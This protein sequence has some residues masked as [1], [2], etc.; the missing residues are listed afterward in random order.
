MSS[1][2]TTAELL[3]IDKPPARATGLAG[4]L[5]TK[6]Q[7]ATPKN[8]APDFAALPQ[9]PTE[10]LQA[11]EKIIRQE[12]N[13]YSMTVRAAK[14]RFTTTGGRA[15]SMIQ[16][17]ELWRD[18]E[19][20]HTDFFSYARTVW[21]YEKSH[22]YLLLDS[23][24]IREAI[25]S[26]EA[27]LNTSHLKIL[28]PALRKDGPEIVQRAWEEADTATGGAITGPA[29]I[30]ALTAVRATRTA[31]TPTPRTDDTAPDSPSSVEAL[32]AALRAQKQVWAAL[33]PATVARAVQHDPERTQALLEELERQAVRTTKRARAAQ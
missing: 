2:P 17:E 29:L 33:A 18:A 9:E 14:E 4:M 19:E 25:S 23:V 10:R 26:P 24:K 22:V 3:G 1:E 31:G 6:R 32:E 13:T 21:G 15:L 30:K 11:L 16:Q 28:G 8:D 27:H 20:T 12:E 7:K 5:G